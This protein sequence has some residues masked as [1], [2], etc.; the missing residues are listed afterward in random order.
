ADHSKLVEWFY[1][2]PMRLHA[3]SHLHCL[4]IMS[5]PNGFVFRAVVCAVLLPM[6]TN[7]AEIVPERVSFELDAMPILT[8]LGCNA[9][10]CH[11]KARGQN[12][13]QL[14]LL[15][16]Y[17][18]FDYAALTQEARARRVSPTAPDESLLLRKATG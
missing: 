9:G 3:K 18:E 5:R 12:G 8:R 7:A 14:S 4:T 16:F 13:F 2:P 10:A 15:G 11:G 1:T 17:P 6:A